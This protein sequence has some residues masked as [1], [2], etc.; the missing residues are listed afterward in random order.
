MCYRRN[1]HNEQDNPFFTQPRMYRAI[2]KQPTVLAQYVKK[3]VDEGTITQ[4][5]Y[6]VS[7]TDLF[8]LVLFVTL[9]S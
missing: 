5:E 8:W 2:E 3:L 1:G 6:E 7:R 4:E 9:R